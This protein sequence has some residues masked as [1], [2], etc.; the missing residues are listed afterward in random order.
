MMELELVS[1]RVRQSMLSDRTAFDAGVLYVNGAELARLLMEDKRLGSVQVELAHP[2]ESC[3][4]VH[5]QD[6]L[7]PRVKV[8]PPGPAFPGVTGPPRMAGSG[9][10]RRLEGVAVVLAGLVPDSDD[11]ALFQESIID[12]T[13]PA[14]E[15]CPFSRTVNIVLSIAP[16][17]GLTLRE[18]TAAMRLAAAR[19]AE[20]LAGAVAHQP[21]DMVERFDLAPISAPLPRVGLLIELEAWGSMQQSFL[22]GLS[23]D[24]L[25]PTL[26]HPNEVLDGALTCGTYHQPAIRHF[27]Y[28]L[29]DHAIIREL[30]RR[31]GRDVDFAGVIV[32]RALWSNYDDKRR[33]AE[34]AAKLLC[35]LDVSGAIVTFAHGGHAITDLVLT[36]EACEARGVSVATLM[37][38]MAGEDGFDFGLVQGA[39]A[40]EPMVSTGNSYG[41]ISLPRVD[42][43][44]GGQALHGLNGHATARRPACEAVELPLSHIVAVSGPT[45]WGRLTARAG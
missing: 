15:A 22:Y 32:Q 42:R 28:L 35:Q 40:A 27:T 24:G 4:I 36:C 31:H 11:P 41:K 8:D 44:L 18:A 29:Q 16:A 2:G 20:Y 13:G 33:S 5:V 38:E 7:E 12:M 9:R 21:S 1:R 3:R 23:V 25:L 10:T 45:G 26:L 43:V 19:S 30:Y 17:T 14:A 39:R 6:V 37:F 34:F